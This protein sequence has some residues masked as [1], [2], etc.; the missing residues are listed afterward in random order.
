MSGSG[1][2]WTGRR[3]SHSSLPVA[4]SIP[5]IA[6]G[7]GVTGGPATAPRISPEPCELIA[8]T[9]GPPPLAATARHPGAYPIFVPPFGFGSTA[10]PHS[11]R[12]TGGGSVGTGGA[13]GTGGGAGAAAHAERTASRDRKSVV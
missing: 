12:P 10:R 3:Y 5:S 4:G 13:G 2:F 9:T 1:Y 7:Y 11:R 8:A 6:L